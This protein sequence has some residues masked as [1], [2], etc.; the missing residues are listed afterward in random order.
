LRLTESF[1]ANEMQW[2]VVIITSGFTLAMF[3]SG[4]RAIRH[5]VMASEKAGMPP[6]LVKG[7][8]ILMMVMAMLALVAGMALGGAFGPI[9]QARNF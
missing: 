3:M 8:G 7:A 2:H 5:S 9:D 1:D 6:R 4:A